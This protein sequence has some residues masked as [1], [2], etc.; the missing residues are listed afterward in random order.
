MQTKRI[1]T[2]TV[3]LMIFNI[4]KILFPF[5]TLPYLTRVLS[6]DTYGSVT[7]VKTVMTYMQIL[8]DFGFVLSATKDI[9]KVREDKTKM[10]YVIGDT[11]IAR[12]ILGIIGFIIIIVLALTFNSCAANAA[13]GG[14]VVD[15][16]RSR[17]GTPTLVV[18]HDGNYTNFKTTEKEYL[19]YDIGEIYAQE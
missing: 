12:I 10:G 13:V 16:Y 11:M 15:K 17:Y 3:M 1:A 2:N 19:E 7:Y 14:T 9:V 6:T 4:A 18:E 8:V 5:F